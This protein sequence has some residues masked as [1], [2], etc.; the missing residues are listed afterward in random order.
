M[1]SD[2]T[3]IKLDDASSDAA[4]ANAW[5]SLTSHLAKSQLVASKGTRRTACSFDAVY[6]TV[7]LDLSTLE[8]GVAPAFSRFRRMTADE[9]PDPDLKERNLLAS[10]A[11]DSDADS[12]E[13]PALGYVSEMVEVEDPVSET[14]VRPLER[15]VTDAV[16][17]DAA[18]GEV[19]GILKRMKSHIY[20]D[21]TTS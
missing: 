5:A 17:A 16:L 9:R 1:E 2:R 10:A 15:V 20:D 13:E 7:A 12:E 3:V 21:D 19:L 4:L 18:D 6:P 8:K 14:T 11:P